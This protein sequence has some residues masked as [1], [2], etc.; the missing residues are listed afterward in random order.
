[1][2]ENADIMEVTHSTTPVSYYLY[3]LTYSDSEDPLRLAAWGADVDFDGYT[4]SASTIKHDEVTT[5]SDG[6]VNDVTVT[7]GNVDRAIQEY[8]EEYD[9]VGNKV[10]VTQ[11]FE[12]EYG[13]IAGSVVV[14][15]T[16]KSIK[17]TEESATFT[18][19]AG[20]DYFQLKFPGRI[21]R[22][23]YCRWRFDDENCKYTSNTGGTDTTCNLTFRDCKNKGNII[24]FGAFP[25]VPS[26]RIYI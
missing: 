13:S 7:V 18:L 16:I 22:S 12:D 24:N 1:M 20:V 11:I 6:K 8:I 15:F 26:S 19:S 2:L 17:A 4:Y 14:E 23:R 10:V 3:E 5:S 9:I 21:V 25:A